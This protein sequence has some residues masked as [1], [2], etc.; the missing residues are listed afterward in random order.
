MFLKKGNTFITRNMF[1]IFNVLHKYVVVRFFL[2]QF[3]YHY[4]TLKISKNQIEEHRTSTCTSL[5]SIYFHC[6]IIHFMCRIMFLF[7]LKLEVI[8]CMILAY[9]L[10]KI[11]KIW[12]FIINKK[13]KKIS[14]RN[15]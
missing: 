1:H 2:K 10:L 9:C 15:I 6:F 13:I 8:L 14:N 4:I 11:W 7:I 3:H 12:H 5:F